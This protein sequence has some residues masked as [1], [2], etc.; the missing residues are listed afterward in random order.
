MKDKKTALNDNSD[1]K[2]KDLEKSKSHSEGKF[3]TTNQGVK[4]NGD[5]NSLKA[6]NRSSA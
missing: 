3:M 2:L 5:N 1:A 4:M 6:G